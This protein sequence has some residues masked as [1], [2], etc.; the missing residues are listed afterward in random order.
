M[1]TPSCTRST[2]IGIFVCS[3]AVLHCSA[4]LHICGASWYLCTK[5]T[6]K[7]GDVEASLPVLLCFAPTQAILSLKE[8]VALVICRQQRDGF[9]LHDLAVPAATSERTP[10]ER[11]QGESAQSLQASAPRT[12]MSA[13]RV[14]RIGL[15]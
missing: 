1:R 5:V 11:V 4:V 3:T 13:I 2:G 12:A 7:L 8:E 15:R 10:C 6:R 14:R 9:S